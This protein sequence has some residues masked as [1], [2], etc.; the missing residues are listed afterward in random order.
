[1][2]DLAQD[3]DVRRMRLQKKPPVSEYP[4]A[5]SIASMSGISLPGND[6]LA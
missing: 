3:K 2:T 5:L 6:P 4:A 1:M